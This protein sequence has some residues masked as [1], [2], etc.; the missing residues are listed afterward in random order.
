MKTSLLKRKETVNDLDLGDG[1][2]RSQEGH[3]ANSL[4]QVW[5]KTVNKKMN[6]FKNSRREI[7]LLKSSTEWVEVFPLYIL[8]T[9]FQVLHHR[10]WAVCAVKTVWSDEN[11]H[12]LRVKWLEIRSW[13]YILVVECWA[14]Y[15]IQRTGVTYLLAELLWVSTKRRRIK[16]FGS[17]PPGH[18]CSGCSC[19]HQLKRCTAM[20]TFSRPRLFLS[21]KPNSSILFRKADQQES[22]K[23][24]E[25]TVVTAP[26]QFIPIFSVSPKS[27][28][29]F[30]RG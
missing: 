22:A 19:A 20:N 3:Y 8:H 17:T 15:H 30:L 29:R 9:L 11:N 4:M 21:Q 7:L 18:Y 25:N 1:Q 14:N 5:K 12:W 2:D 28:E 26:S 16:T 6:A 10:N 23:E 27:K 13:L 24:N